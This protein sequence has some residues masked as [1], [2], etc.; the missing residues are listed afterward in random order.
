MI[1]RSIFLNPSYSTRVAKCSTKRSPFAFRL[2]NL[3]IISKFP[4]QPDKLLSCCMSYIATFKGV[5]SSLCRKTVNWHKICYSVAQSSIPLQITRFLDDSLIS[6]Q[7]VTKH[8]DFFLPYTKTGSA[9]WLHKGWPWWCLFLFCL[10]VE[11]N[12]SVNFE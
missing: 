7:V 8:R 4:I 6:L 2:Y 11:T 1:H 10:V 9:L 12:D 5:M 3:I